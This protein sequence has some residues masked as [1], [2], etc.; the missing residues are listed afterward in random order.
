M[1]PLSAESSSPRRE[2]MFVSNV[3]NYLSIS[4]VKH[5]EW[6]VSLSDLKLFM[7]VGSL[8]LVLLG[9]TLWNCRWL[10]SFGGMS[11][12]RMKA[13]CFLKMLVTMCIVIIQKTTVLKTLNMMSKRSETRF[14][15]VYWQE[16]LK[17]RYQED[18][19]RAV[20]LAFGVFHLDI[21]HCTLALLMQ[22]LPQYLYNRLQWVSTV[23]FTL[24][25]LT[26]SMKL[27]VAHSFK[28][29]LIF[30]GNLHF[31]TVKFEVVAG[32]ST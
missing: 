24:T 6:L 22:V 14:I 7:A 19:D 31:I 4:M 3:Y 8:V 9:M 5:P 2:G 1:V 26:Y 32:V 16:V 18:L 15:F 30:C 29:L 11:F 25:K 28:K 21:E 12:L 20:D 10:Q 27:T 13:A 23:H 17:F